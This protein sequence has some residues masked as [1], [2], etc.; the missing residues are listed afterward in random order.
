MVTIDSASQVGFGTRSWSG[1]QEQ[2]LAL[3]AALESGCSLIDVAWP[4]VAD[5]VEAEVGQV[6]SGLL[7]DAV[8]LAGADRLTPGDITERVRIAA[9]RLRRDRLDVL[10]LDQPGRLLSAR[11]GPDRLAEAMA[12]C[13]SL[14]DRGCLGGYGLRLSGSPSRGT[15][16][17]ALVL[18]PTLATPAALISHCL[19]VAGQV[20]INHRLTVIQAPCDLLRPPGRQSPTDLT[21]VV[22]RANLALVGTRP[23]PVWPVVG[24]VSTTVCD[25]YLKS[26]IDHIIVDP[27]T[28]RQVSALARILQAPG[29]ARGAPRRARLENAQ[30]LS[31]WIRTGSPRRPSSALG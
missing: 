15:S 19:D 9:T 23:L 24:Q 8:I 4:R 31:Q 7:T 14:I 18:A 6:L 28:P 1:T 25:D 26:G 10:L 22:R 2:V 29:P 21:E 27:R 30:T 20:N 17:A 5:Q 13:E 12:T 3:R 11:N 16:T